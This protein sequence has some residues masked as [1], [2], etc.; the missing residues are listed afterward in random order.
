MIRSTLVQFKP[1]RKK[2]RKKETK[3]EKEECCGCRIQHFTNAE[4]GS[5][6]SAALANS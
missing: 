6:Y 2:G 5:S 4:S 3:K 1:E